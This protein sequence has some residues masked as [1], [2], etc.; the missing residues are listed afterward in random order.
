MG[1][2]IDLKGQVFGFLRAEEKMP[3]KE[4]RYVVWRC[5][6]TNCGG[7]ASVNTNHLKRK[8]VTNC[9]CIPKMAAQNGSKAEDLTG[10][11]FGDLKAL[12]RVENHR[13]GRTQWMCECTC[14]NRVVVTAHELKTEKTKSCGCHKKNNPGYAL[15]LRN[16]RFGRLTTLS[17]TEKRDKKGSVIWHCRCWCGNELDISADA[18]MHGN[19]RSCGCLKQELME[20]IGNTLHHVDDTCV[21][22]LEKR[23]HRSDNTSGFRGV[24]AR[25]NGRFQVVIGFKKQ[26]FNIGTFDTFEEAVQER[27]GAEKILHDGFV[28]AY[29]L[30]AERALFDQIWAEKHPFYYNV[31]KEGTQFYVSTVALNDDILDTE[32]MTVTLPAFHALAVLASEIEQKVKPGIL[33]WRKKHNNLV[34]TSK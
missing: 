19:Y 3:Y 22:I 8:I 26:K 10:R 34:Q 18:L 30:W 6:C 4:N 5:H 11:T 15:N 28:K 27:I 17:P 25:D 9:G 2:E 20:Q 14:K 21:E 12:Y 23:K 29:Y 31:K 24:Y 13:N 7:E 32:N 16:R 1:R 33:T